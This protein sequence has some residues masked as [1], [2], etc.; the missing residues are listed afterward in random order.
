MIA[1]LRVLKAAPRAPRDVWA[2][3]VD[4]AGSRMS[5][6]T[7]RFI[8]GDVSEAEYVLAMRS[9]VKSMHMGALAVGSGG[10]ENVPPRELS[11]LGSL[12]R[13]EY[14]YIARKVGRIQSDEVNADEEIRRVVG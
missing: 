8:A 12:L 7:E 4:R 14:K 9:L 2:E 11:R 1:R 3:V 6:L 5:T 13:E 10:I